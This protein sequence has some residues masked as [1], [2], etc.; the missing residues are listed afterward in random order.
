MIFFSCTSS[1]ILRMTPLSPPFFTAY[2]SSVTMI[3]S[4][5]CES[6]SEWARARMRT[7]PRPVS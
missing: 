1:A 2:G 5:P 3:A 4:L 7:R 6:G